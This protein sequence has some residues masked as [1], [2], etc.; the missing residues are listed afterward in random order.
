MTLFNSL[1]VSHAF[2]TTLAKNEPGF[3]K[4]NWAIDYRVLS[5]DG[6]PIVMEEFSNSITQS[7]KNLET[8]IGKLFV[9]CNYS[10][11]LQHISE[12]LKPDDPKNWIRDDPHNREYGHSLVTNPMNGFTAFGP[13]KEDVRYRLLSHLSR[14][15]RFFTPVC[16]SGKSIP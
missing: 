13:E 2:F 10:D 4:F 16:N 6:K 15:E 5:M 12:R 1:K 11:I 8:L 3:A 14:Q 9:G 7:T